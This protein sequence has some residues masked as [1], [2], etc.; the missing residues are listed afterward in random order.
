M[1]VWILPKGTILESST[2]YQELTN[3]QVIADL[4]SNAEPF[5]YVNPIMMVAPLVSMPKAPDCPSPL[6]QS[7]MAISEITISN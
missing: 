6:D 2:A 3:A 5:H 7:N 4:Y 1:V